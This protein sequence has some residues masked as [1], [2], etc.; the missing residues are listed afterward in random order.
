MLRLR[1]VARRY[2][3]GAGV[4]DL[5]LA[6]E[7]GAVHA[8]LGMNGAGKTT[9]LRLALGMLR[10]DAGRVE[11][12]GHDVAAAPAAVLREVGQMVGRPFAYPELTVRENLRIAARL[13]GCE[14]RAVDAA[15]ELWGLEAV[16]GTRFRRLSSG[17][18]Q[19]VGLASA[20]QHR[21]RLIVLDEPSLALDPSSM[22][23]LRTH[24]RRRADEGAAV[25]VSSHHLDEVARIAGR[26]DVMNAGRLIGQLDPRAPDLERALF[27]RILEDDRSRAE[28][29]R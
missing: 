18:A 29:P 6:V 24:L 20:L 1:G 4:R 2:R 26:I 11:I 3:G 15:L 19:R 14:A 21:P 16:A 5:D 28:G 7:E 9:L 17:T 8:L 10:P 12:L 23:V 25:L 22:I 27:A 13:R